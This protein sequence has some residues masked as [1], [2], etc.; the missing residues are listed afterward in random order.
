MQTEF[1]Y[2]ELLHSERFLEVLVDRVA[3][4]IGEKLV[5]AVTEELE[6]Y[7]SKERLRRLVEDRLAQ[8]VQE[9]I[10]PEVLKNLDAKL[11]ANLM[12]PQAAH[13]TLERLLDPVRGQR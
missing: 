1:K 4:K 7:D 6:R 10:L 8:A 13:A 2:G 12:L 5:P 11:I 3:E 9:K